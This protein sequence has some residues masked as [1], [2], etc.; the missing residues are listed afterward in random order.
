MYHEQVRICIA[1]LHYDPALADQRPRHYLAGLPV[2]GYLARALA[3]RGHQVEAVLLFARGA[4]FVEG[5]VTYHLVP[6]GPG[7]ER[8]GR[9]GVRLLPAL[10]ALWRI[11]RLQADVIHCHGLVLT[12]NLAGLR[13]V[14]GRNGP[15][16]V[17]HYHGG[18]PARRRLAHRLQRYALRRLSR[19][20]FTTRAQAQPFLEAGVL[21]PGQVGELM[22]VST[23]FRMQNRTV[24]RQETGMH[25]DPVFLWAG[26]LHPVKGPQTALKGFARIQAAWPGA[27]LYLYYLSDELLPRLR[28]SLATQP[29]LRAHVHFRGRVPHAQMEA[30]FNSADFFLQAS[31][32]EYS[33]FAVLEA[34]ACGVLPVVSDIPAFRIMSGDGAYGLLFP[35]GDAAALARQVLAVDPAAIPR[36]A[37][38]R[39][40]ERHFSF[41]KMAERLETV[42]REVL[43]EKGQPGRSG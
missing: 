42:Y 11:R 17:G 36:A 40:F 10:P 35:P 43:A 19:A 30:V 15:P 37:I 9:Q 21:R 24:A 29:G 27:H 13:L 18:L 26:R 8:L 2:E 12:V 23:P 28:A 1:S 34:L 14:L 3:A 38:R 39:H 32:R 16:I 33:G 22:E 6:A 5:D 31:V 25:G 41:E 7:L 4:R 20:L